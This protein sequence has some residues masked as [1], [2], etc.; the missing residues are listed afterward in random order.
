MWRIYAFIL[1][2]FVIHEN[3]E[4]ERERERKSDCEWGA[5]RRETRETMKLNIFI[6]KWATHIF[7]L[8]C[9]LNWIVEDRICTFAH[10]Y[11]R[12]VAVL[13]ITPQSLVSLSLSSLQSFV[14]EHS[15]SVV[16][17]TGALCDGTKFQIIKMF[18]RDVT[19]GTFN[20]LLLYRRFVRVDYV[21]QKFQIY[22]SVF[23][24][25]QSFS[26]GFG[27]DRVRNKFIC[28]ILRLIK[29][30]LDKWWNMQS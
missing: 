28:V 22:S 18:L 2:C 7:Y 12:R 9:L 29:K 10:L 19:V 13:H 24:H 14:V 17:T 11:K 3:E 27:M 20:I 1:N 8:V 6:R 23:A 5:R 15:M 30:T 21:E 4:I 26:E 25:S 16:D